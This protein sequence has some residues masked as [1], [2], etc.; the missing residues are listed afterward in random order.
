MNYLSYWMSDM[1]GASRC[2]T[3]TQKKQDLIPFII[4]FPKCGV[5][6]IMIQPHLTAYLKKE[7][8]YS[9]NSTGIVLKPKPKIPCPNKEKKYKKKTLGMLGM[10]SRFSGS[11][12]LLTPSYI[13]IV[14]L[15]FPTV[16]SCCFVLLRFV[17]YLYSNSK[18]SSNL[19]VRRDFNSHLRS[20]I[21]C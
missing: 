17:F 5:L 2:S 15:L 13:H 4:F 6:L 7:H 14:F 3:M 11:H 8:R 9:Y 18:K 16:L 21:F 10:I 12:F 1:L 19:K 20:H